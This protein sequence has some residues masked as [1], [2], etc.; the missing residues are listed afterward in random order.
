MFVRFLLT[1]LSL[2]TIA[3]SAAFQMH[4][5]SKSRH[6]P[7]NININTNTNT[8]TNT[9]NHVNKIA[10]PVP[11]NRNKSLVVRQASIDAEIPGIKRKKRS[12]LDLNLPWGNRQAWALKDCLNKYLV[13][14]PQL[15]NVNGNGDCTYVMWRAMSRENIELAGYDI[16]FLR[17]KYAQMLEDD[18]GDDDDGG[19]ALT[20]AKAPGA[21]PLLDNFEFE[22]NGGVSGNIQGLRGIADGTIAQTSSLA[23]VQLTVPRG[24]VMTE[25]GSSAYEL[26]SPLSEENFSID[27]ARMDI[28][29]NADDVKRKLKSGAEETGKVASSIALSAGDEET[30]K[31]LFNLGA[32]TAILL[33][34]A[35]AMN[36]LAHHLTVN[37]FWV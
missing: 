13:E 2:T 34:G 11:S 6:G 8:N 18:D 30:T 31:M 32:T 37:V 21:L 7:N 29:V 20:P 14:I 1:S 17:T 24:Y 36:M 5:S 16:E 33:G 26:G 9:N 15:E 35:T 12:N 28:N 22:S 27:I 3:S 25:D 10:S 19:G 23:Y 4:R